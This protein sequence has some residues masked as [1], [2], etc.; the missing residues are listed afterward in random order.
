[1]TIFLSWSKPKS[2]E[3]AFE[4]KKF[5]E[6]LFRNQVKIWMSSE[7]IPFGSMSMLDINSALKSSDKCITFITEENF[8]NPWLM[9]EAGAVASRNYLENQKNED[10]VIPIVFD[11]LPSN[12]FYGHPLNQFQRLNF[13]KES[14]HK[15]I[16]QFNKRINAFSDEKILN[17]QFNLNWSILNKNVKS[18]LRKY[19]LNTKKCVTCEFLIDAFEKEKFPTP[20]R[21]PIIKYDSG[22]ETQKLY[23]VLLKNVDKR[24]YV[25]GRKNRKLF[26]T[27]NRSFFSDLDRRIKNGFDFKCLFIDPSCEKAEKAQRGNNF[28]NKLISCLN[29]A[30]E[31]LKNNGIQPQ[32][33]CRLY[34]CDRTDEIIIIDNAVLYSHITYSNDDYPYPLTKAPFYILDIDNPIGQKYFNRFNDVWTHAKTFD[35]IK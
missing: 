12:I 25:F 17:T 18:I 1:M 33:I 19:S 20:D 28:Q 11:N 13:N 21:G 32:N 9:Y 10:A 27:E 4:T 26:S 24:L 14:M 3:I 16:I 30:H 22:F 34:D 31:V 35:Y 7:S 2:R 23:E 29:E 5:L 15:L 8:N 6:G